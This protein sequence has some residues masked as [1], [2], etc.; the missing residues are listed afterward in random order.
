M[1]E[2][3]KRSTDSYPKIYRLS[4]E[5]LSKLPFHCKVDGVKRLAAIG[6]PVHLAVHIINE[7]K[8]S[9]QEYVLPHRH[10]KS[11][12]NLILSEK[13]HLAFQI[14]VDNQEFRVDSPAAV[15]IPENVTHSAKFI[16]G[17]GFF[18]CLVLDQAYQAFNEM[19]K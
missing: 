13:G 12:L 3:N 4:E 2:E 11:E 19:K 15:W 16:E 17:S 14:A 7:N 10:R 5:D 18:I 8:K 9:P 6:L 1:S